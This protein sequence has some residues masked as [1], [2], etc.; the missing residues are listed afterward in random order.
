MN[1][2]SLKLFSIFSFICIMLCNLRAQE[3]CA[4][5]LSKAQKLYDAGVIEQIPQMLQQCLIKGF[6]DEEKLQ[7]NKLIIMSYLFDNN[8]TKADKAMLEFLKRYPEYALLPSDPA[9]FVQ[10]FKTYRTYPV[11]SFGFIFGTNISSVNVTKLYVDPSIKGSYANT[12]F[13]YHGGLSF[14]RYLMNKLDLNLEAIYVLN[15][16]KYSS[17]AITSN[18][19]HEFTETM[20]SLAFPLTAIYTP[21]YS[22]K[23]VPYLRGGVSFSYL[24]SSTAT[25]SLTIPDVSKPI[26]QPDFS[27]TDYRVRFMVKPVIGAGINYNLNHGNLYLDIRYDIGLM[28]HINTDKK[29]EENQDIID[30]Q[31]TYAYRDNYFRI[32]NICFSIGYFYKFYKPEKRK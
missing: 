9:E 21:L 7:A 31:W 16:Y 23:I 11:A 27:I 3:D 2:V 32:N 19:S 29:I 5:T 18:N 8:T 12:G 10:L 26:T 1:R 14:K 24:L 20:T 28:N 6:S 17:D 15:S 25:L 22:K 13:T 4:T 30:A